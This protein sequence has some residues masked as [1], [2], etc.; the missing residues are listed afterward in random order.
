LWRLQQ[1]VLLLVLSGHSLSEI[2]RNYPLA[3]RTIRRWKKWF[4][5]EFLNHTNA[6][7]EYFPDLGRHQEHTSFWPVCFKQMSLADAMFYVQQGGGS[8]P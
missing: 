3:R 5:L 2:S 6:I 8:V 1:T 7:K 4:E